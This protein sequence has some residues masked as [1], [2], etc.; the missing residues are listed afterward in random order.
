MKL[1]SGFT[2]IDKMTGGFSTGK[3]YAICGRPVEGKTSLAMSIC[4]NMAFKSKIPTALF[5]LE[6]PIKHIISR[7]RL[8][9]DY[10]EESAIHI[11]DWS[12]DSTYSS[13][14]YPY[15]EKGPSDLKLLFIDDDPESTI[16]ILNEKIRNLVND[17]GV[18][19]VCIDYLELAAN[20]SEREFVLKRLKGTAAE[21]NIVVIITSMLHRF[22]YAQDDRNP[23]FCGK[24][25]IIHKILIDNCDRVLV[26]HRPEAH[27]RVDSEIKAKVD[28]YTEVHILQYKNF[29]SKFGVIKFNRDK[30]RFDNHTYKTK[31]TI[32]R[33]IYAQA[34]IY[35]YWLDDLKYIKNHPHWMWFIFPQLKGLGRSSTSM[36]YGLNDADEA[37]VY[38]NH[39]V[40]GKR[41]REISNTLIELPINNAHEIFGSP[42]DMKLRS[43][44]TLFDTIEPNSIFQEVLD[45]FFHGSKDNRTLSILNHNNKNDKNNNQ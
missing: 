29:N 18:R 31:S 6:V 39:P 9:E 25:N 20:Y 43:C 4:C 24:Q 36:Y 23:I 21:L 32:Y 28:G 35:Y 14:L 38:L 30:R 8:M 37:R 12:P 2:T 42:D 40:L 41:L 13:D 5:S 19:M 33:F 7:L 10:I 45:K 1:S 17:Y 34:G 27:I 16:S 11:I 22:S 15:L 26:I 3:I 44:M